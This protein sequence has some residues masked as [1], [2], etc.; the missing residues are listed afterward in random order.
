M[1][2]G[3]PPGMPLDTATRKGLIS[4]CTH[5]PES[6]FTQGQGP[7]LIKGPNAIPLRPIIPSKS[8]ADVL[9]TLSRKFVPPVAG[10]CDTYKPPKGLGPED[11]LLLYQV[12][13]FLIS[14]NT[15]CTR[16]LY[17][18]YLK[19]FINP[20]EQP[21]YPVERLFEFSAMQDI[22]FYMIAAIASTLPVT[23]IFLPTLQLFLLFTLRDT[24][25]LGTF[26]FYSPT[27]EAV[28]KAASADKRQ[29]KAFTKN[30]VDEFFYNNFDLTKTILRLPCT[31]L[32]TYIKLYEEGIIDFVDPN[33]FFYEVAE[34]SRSIIP[35]CLSIEFKSKK[36]GN[37]LTLETSSVKEV[38]S[39]YFVN[40]KDM[41]LWDALIERARN[42]GIRNAEDFH[43]PI[44][45][46]IIALQNIS[47]L[48]STDNSNCSCFEP[49]LECREVTPNSEEKDLQS[50][51][52]VSTSSQDSN[53]L[54]DDKSS[55]KLINE[56]TD[57]LP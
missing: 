12:D 36:V 3:T 14:E 57:P 52:Q 4:F 2:Y 41:D 46:S 18:F 38:M 11:L 25:D 42:F 53:A 19:S 17:N 34:S 35:I 28:Y 6:L 29:E 56:P 21:P 22:I 49:I 20:F 26:T 8:E 47:Y 55:L 44:C 43:K 23:M 50:D 39:N 32:N 33:E 45:I 1:P 5:S 16:G 24:G 10:G 37:E 51:T 40:T 31:P 15:K 30:F 9:S 54:P 48:F 13:S 27:P 7:P